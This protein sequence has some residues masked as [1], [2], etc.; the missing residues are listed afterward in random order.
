ML[1]ILYV[2]AM[3]A[4]VGGTAWAAAGVRSERQHSAGGVGIVLL[5]ALQ[6]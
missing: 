2:L 6:R 3:I 1:R 5:A 4:L